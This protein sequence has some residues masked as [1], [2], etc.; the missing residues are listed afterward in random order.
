MRRFTFLFVVLL[1]LAC[2]Q[3]EAIKT[4]GP[5]QSTKELFAYAPKDTELAIAIRDLDLVHRNGAALLQFLTSIPS[6]RQQ[7]EDWEEW[8]EEKLNKSPLDPTFLSSLQLAP[9]KGAALFFSVRDGQPR[10]LAVI[11]VRQLEQFKA[12]FLSNGRRLFGED[13]RIE[14]R[15]LGKDGDIV[16]YDIKPG[17]GSK[18]PALIFAFRDGYILVSDQEPAVREAAL[19]QGNII[20]GQVEERGGD[21]PKESHDALLYFNLDGAR[22]QQFRSNL[23]PVKGITESWRSIIATGRFE[24]NI[25]LFDS[26]LSAPEAKNL[27]P[28]FERNGGRGDILSVAGSETVSA[29]KITLNAARIWQKYSELPITSSSSALRISELFQA[30][31]GLRLSDK[32]DGILDNLTG[33]VAYVSGPGVVDFAVLFGVKKPESFEKLLDVLWVYLKGAEQISRADLA[34]GGF[35]IGFV[36]PREEG[37]RKIYRA[38][39]RQKNVPVPFEIEA[40]T[41]SDSIVFAVGTEWLGRASSRAGK[42]ASPYYRSL[43]HADVRQLFEQNPEAIAHVQFLDPFEGLESTPGELSQAIAASMKDPKLGES[44]EIARM[45]MSHIFDMTSAFF[46]RDNGFEWKLRFTLM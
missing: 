4:D 18:L 25:L 1:S 35:S 22:G 15:E 45:L 11:A 20:W 13:L 12:A 34:K 39:L 23:L 3:S 41:T 28:Y 2:G 14:K 31:T 46:I 21:L 33:E 16:L 44:I 42:G 32:E 17:V 19:S 37:G 8:G 29:A 9:E 36:D 30:A 6:I 40:G 7:V 24:N 5:V 43:Y 38:E 27:R 26:F 10:R